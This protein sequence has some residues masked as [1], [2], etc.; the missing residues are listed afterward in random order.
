MQNEQRLAFPA[1]E[2]VQLGLSDLDGFICVYFGHALPLPVIPY[3]SGL[4]SWLR[5][6]NRSGFMPLRR[7]ALRS[8]CCCGQAL[9]WSLALLARTL[10]KAMY[11][12]KQIS[13]KR[14]AGR[15]D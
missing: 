4:L 12:V 8:S 3:L 11:P 2:Q 15:L 14:L 9:Q 1:S 10:A 5:R 7:E 13:A 6:V